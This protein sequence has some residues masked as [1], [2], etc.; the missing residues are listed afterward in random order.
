MIRTHV[1]NKDTRA[2]Y[3]LLYIFSFDAY[4]A[5]L[6]AIKKFLANPLLTSIISPIDPNL[7]KFSN[8]IDSFDFKISTDYNFFVD[9]P[10][11]STDLLLSNSF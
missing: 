8:K 3:F 1:L 6:F 5:F 4:K 2:S 11:Y 10:N 9:K 7:L